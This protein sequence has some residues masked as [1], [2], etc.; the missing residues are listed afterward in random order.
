MGLRYREWRGAASRASAQCRVPGFAAAMSDVPLSVGEAPG[1]RASQCPA[2]TEV[3]VC[4]C[5]KSYGGA[6]LD[7]QL[8]LELIRETPLM[9]RQLLGQA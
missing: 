8:G 9:Y 2:S 1:T 5:Q 6:E 4:S 7:E 3:L